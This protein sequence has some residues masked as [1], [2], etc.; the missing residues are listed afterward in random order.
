MYCLLISSYQSDCPS[1][2]FPSPKYTTYRKS[3]P[4]E[5]HAADTN[6]FGGFFKQ[7][8]ISYPAASLV[9]PGFADSDIVS[10]LLIGQSVSLEESTQV[11][12]SFLA[13]HALITAGRG[14]QPSIPQGFIELVKQVVN[15]A[16]APALSNQVR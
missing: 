3:S 8:C 10:R 7:I 1:P 13:L 16:K 6:I 11:A 2:F 15:K 12:D 4:D 9:V 5:W 14:G